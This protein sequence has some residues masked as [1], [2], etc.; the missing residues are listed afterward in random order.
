MSNPDDIRKLAEATLE[1]D[2]A[3]TPGPWTVG[4]GGMFLDA[5]TGSVAMLT[6]EETS[7]A[8]SAADTRGQRKRNGIAI[9]HA[10][11]A[12]P[13]L[14]HAVLD[15]LRYRQAVTEVLD[16]GASGG[17]GGSVYADRIRAAIARKLETKDG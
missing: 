10:R 17:H 8:C 12:A 1:H 4:H 16:E 15:L 5:S 7:D 6:C 11:T 3:A 14:A 9:A 2:K 13:D